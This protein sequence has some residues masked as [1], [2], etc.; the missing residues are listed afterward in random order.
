M[1]K[2]IRQLAALGLACL[3]VL[4]GCGE[5]KEES[6]AEPVIE[7][8]EEVI[9]EIEEPAVPE[10][11]QKLPLNVH[12]TENQKTYYFEEGEQAY[13]Y[14]QYCDVEISGDGYDSL[15]RNVE[16]WSMERSEG[17][18]SLYSSFEETAAE[19]AEGNENFYGYS[20][21]QTVST[22]RADE[23]VLSL[24]DDT[25]QYSGGEHG[26]HYREGVNF[27]AQ[28]GKRL[29]LTDVISDWENFSKDASSS[30]IY[31]L[32]E[33]YGEELNDDYVTTVEGLWTEDTEP[34]WYLDASSIVITLQEYQVGPY[35]VGMPE[36]HLPYAEFSPYIKVAY[37]PGTG[38]GAAQFQANQEIFLELEGSYDEVPMMLQ[39]DVSEENAHCSLWLGENEKTLGEFMVLGNA[40]LLRSDEEIYCLIEMDVVSDAYETYVYR[41]TEGVI[42]E[43]ARLDGSVDAGNVNPDGI[44]INSRVY[45]LGTYGGT[46]TYHFDD[47][48][49]FVTED[50]EYILKSNEMVLT[51]KTDLS[52]TLEETPNVLPA[53]SNI[54]LTSTDGET[55]VNFTIQ[56]TGQTGTLAVERE[57]GETY[58]LLVDGKD[59]YDCFETL[60]YAG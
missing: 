43:V 21:Y 4:G 49:Q 51:T 39:Y 8:I 11:E 25:Y 47:K 31:Y 23:S 45:L 37:L 40:Y 46:K 36:I 9:E 56:E 12:V 2:R 58:R 27:D 1:K 32:K 33:T 48:G 57:E 29:K 60:P 24:K 54:V 7:E 34:D 6:A 30:M 28:T 53:G 13:L 18:R 14:L 22:A 3:L 59:E 16:K 55:Y 35:S 19:E 20:L 10:E 26:M 38:E 44:M 5:K 50:T 17:L 52:V 42:K 41:L 15:K